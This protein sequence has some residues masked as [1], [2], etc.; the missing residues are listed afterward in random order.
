M[1]KH[2]TLFL[3]CLCLTLSL[4]VSAPTVHAQAPGLTT[5]DFPNATET[6]CNDINNVGVIVGHYVDSSGNNHGF[7]RINGA[8]QTVDV[9]SAA[10]TYLYGVNDNGTAVGWYVDASNI[11]H[12]FAITRSGTVTTIDPPG[13][14]LTNAWSINSKGVIV[15]AYTNSAGTYNGFILSG[16]KY[17]TYTAPNGA[18]L[19]EMTGIN[20][21][22]D[23]VGIFDDS[24]GEEHGFSL[25]KGKF[26]QIDYPGS[27]IVV[28]ATDR[29]NNLGEIVGLYGTNVNGPFTGYDAKNGT[30]NSISFPGAFETRTRGLNDKAVVVGRYTDS[31]GNIHGYYG[32]P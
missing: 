30:F 15:G 24:T 18:L 14:T 26:T 12:G 28:T 4:T 29:V 2:A 22:G 9:P 25:V 1:P 13:T 6:E 23:I 31:E 8:M 16:G 27:G 32:V 11:T 20:D 5:L 10:A 21:A 7:A 19:T 17:T 3:S